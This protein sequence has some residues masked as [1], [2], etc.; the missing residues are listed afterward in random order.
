[1]ACSNSGK[2]FIDFL[3]TVSGGTLANSSYL[4]QLTHYTCGGRK[5]CVGNNTFYPVSADLKFQVVGTPVDVGNGTFCCEVLCT[6][7]CTYMPFCCGACPRTENIYCTFCVPC[8][9]AAV[10]TITAGTAQ[11]TPTNLQQCCNLTNAVA[12]TSTLNVVTA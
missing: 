11:A 10:P 8:S 9:S 6:G 5:I 2:T 7:T 3:T 4:L 12:I 1:M